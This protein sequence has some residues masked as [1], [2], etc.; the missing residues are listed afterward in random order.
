MGVKVIPEMYT[1]AKFKKVLKMLDYC[2]I[3]NLAVRQTDKSKYSPF[4][5][6]TVFKYTLV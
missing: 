4:L 5:T 6:E 3:P 2:G 1:I